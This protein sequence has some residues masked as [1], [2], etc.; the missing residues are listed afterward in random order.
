VT[1][2]GSEILA[3]VWEL[4]AMEDRESEDEPWTQTF[5]EDPRGVVVY[6]PT[7]FLSVQVF[8]GSEAPWVPYL[9]YIGYWVLR[10]V[11][12]ADGRME[13]VVE[14]RIAASSL[15]EVLEE[16]PARPFVL[17]GDELH[18]GDDRTY[19]RTFRRLRAGSSL[20]M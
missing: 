9:G 20:L 8:A 7:G 18:L 11:T 5:G 10:E 1:Q 16:D 15:A 4:V 14:H 17:V 19:R 12:E 13:G 3:G 2:D 6:H